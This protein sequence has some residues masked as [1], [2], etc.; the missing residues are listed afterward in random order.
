ML[1]AKTLFLS[2]QSR[3]L[4]KTFQIPSQVFIR[5]M[6]TLEDH[7]HPEVPYHN[8]IHAGDV[9]QSV[10]VLLLS[11]ALDVSCFHPLPPCFFLRK[12]IL[13]TQSFFS[14]SLLNWK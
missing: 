13:L 9:A 5:L 14:L 12:A 8:S 10:H 2:A 4:M 1:K 6:M 7:Y 3:D 11:P